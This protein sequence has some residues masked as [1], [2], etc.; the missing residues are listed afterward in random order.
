MPNIDSERHLHRCG[1]P[2]LDK[3]IR[4]DQLEAVRLSVARAIPVNILLGV[5]SII[6]AYHSEH[7]STGVI[8]FMA[9]TFANLLR[10]GLCRARCPGLSLNSS[11]PPELSRVAERSIDLHLRLAWIGALLSGFVWAC[12]PILCNGY[13]SAQTLFYLTVTCGITAGAVVYGTA[14]A[15]IPFC[16]IAPA[17]TSVVC[18]LLYTGGFD[19]YFLAA[20]VLLYLV[21]LTRSAAETEKGFRET[22]RL[23]FEA[24]AWAQASDAAHAKAQALADEMQQRATYDDLTGLLNR[25]G[26]VQISAERFLGHSETRCLLLLDLDGFKSVNDLYGHSAGDR[27]LKEVAHRIQ[28]VLPLECFA[29]RL[30]GDEFAILYDPQTVSEPPTALAERLIGAVA[31]PFE[32][33]D[34]GRLGLS[35]GIY[36]EIANSITNMLSYADEALYAAK[37]AGRNRYRVFDETL[38]NQ[39]QMRRDIKRDLTRALAEGELD[40]WFQPIFG[41]GGRKL[42]SLEAL[43]RWHHPAHGWIPPGDIIGVAAMSGLTESLLRFILERVCTMMLALVNQGRS[44]IV[45]AMNLSP[46]EMAQIPVDEIVLD[47]L[48]AFGLP[49]KMLEI[50]ITEETALDIEAVQDKL[51]A[52]SRAG[53]RLTVDDFGVGYSSLASLR[54]LR[55]SRLKIDRSLVTGLTESD[56]K[57]GLVMAMVGLGLALKLEIV[58]EGVETADDLE[59]LQGMGCKFFQ[60]YYLG[61]P[62]TASSAIKFVLSGAADAA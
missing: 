22:T 16:F 27:V 4:R 11:T 44:D 40:V 49:A 8:W 20:T 59:T 33:F 14:F 23:K 9:S 41:L 34:A 18:C 61:R 46:R 48:R 6:V 50:E 25:A 31:K 35:I 12:L 58:A 19:R 52:L 29:A 17:L 53:I 60:G 37:G 45:I 10:L 55:A 51:Q 3:L 5:A 57:K 43:V 2:D 56:D 38:R 1:G 13:T 62:G 42:T 15:L 7:G 26:F 21:A 28:E 54:Q 47:R 39:L 36:N 32:S 24:T 30:G